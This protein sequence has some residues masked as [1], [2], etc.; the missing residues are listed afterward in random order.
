M[1][2]RSEWGGLLRVE[3]G[4]QVAEELAVR[5]G[6]RGE[7]VFRGAAAGLAQFVADGGAAVGEAQQ[8][9]AAVAWVDLA[10]DQA[11]FLQGVDHRGERARHDAEVVGELGHPGRLVAAADHAQGALLSRG[12]AKRREPFRLRPA[13]PPRQPV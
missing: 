2:A 1:S 12:E 5:G 7:E 4:E 10:A 3:A 9:G 8:D 13:H 11:R 6:Q